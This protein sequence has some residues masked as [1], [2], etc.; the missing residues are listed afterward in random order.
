MTK[1]QQ[2]DTIIVQKARLFGVSSLEEFAEIS[3]NLNVF[4]YGTGE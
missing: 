3:P 4:L 2:I 1:M